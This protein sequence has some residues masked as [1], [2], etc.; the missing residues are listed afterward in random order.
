MNTECIQDK[1]S[2]PILSINNVWKNVSSKIK[3]P[4]NICNLNCE[5][6]VC[7]IKRWR[8]APKRYVV[9]YQKQSVV[10]T[11]RNNQIEILKNTKKNCISITKTNLK[12]NVIENPYFN[13]EDIQIFRTIKNYSELKKWIL[14]HGWYKVNGKNH[15][16]YRLKNTTYQ[17]SLACTPSDPRSLENEKRNI[18]K[19][20]IQLNT[21]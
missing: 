14:T 16:K 19:G 20:M 9:K 18:R 3:E 8:K 6:N 2:N 12:P 5:C 21:T 11:P 17:I 13:R 4:I 10:T 15:D 7:V 1:K